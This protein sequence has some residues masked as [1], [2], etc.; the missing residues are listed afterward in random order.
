MFADELTVAKKAPNT[1]DR[2]VMT[3]VEEWGAGS[4][5]GSIAAGLINFLNSKSKIGRICNPGD[6]DNCENMF[7]FILSFLLFSAISAQAITNPSDGLTI[8]RLSKLS[9]EQLWEIVSSI[10]THAHVTHVT[11]QHHHRSL[12]SISSIDPAQEIVTVRS[13]ASNYHMTTVGGSD[14]DK[15]QPLYQPSLEGYFPANGYET[16]TPQCKRILN[17]YLGTCMLSDKPGATRFQQVSLMSQQQQQR[18]HHHLPQEAYA[19]SRGQDADYIRDMK[20]AQNI[21]D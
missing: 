9:I 21:I 5:S 1:I 2:M 14:V 8:E 16:S 17:R 20:F 6:L 18:V 19:L 11:Q 13:H 15:E 10:P 12:L 3:D 4:S 7:M